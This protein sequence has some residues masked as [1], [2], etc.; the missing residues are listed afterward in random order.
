MPDA[1]T[2]L[3]HHFEQLTQ[4]SGIA[5]EVIRGRGYCLIVPPEGYTVLKQLGIA[6]AQAKLTPGLLIPILDIDGQPV[7]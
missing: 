7:L 4:G 5:P 1:P 6:R 3:P 2:L